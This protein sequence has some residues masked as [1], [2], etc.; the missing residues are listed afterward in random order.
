MTIDTFPDSIAIS[1]WC[2]IHRW[3]NLPY[4]CSYFTMRISCATA[5]LWDASSIYKSGIDFTS[6]WH[7]RWKHMQHKISWLSWCFFHQHDSLRDVFIQKCVHACAVHLQTSRRT[8][9]ASMCF[10]NFRQFLTFVPNFGA[11]QASSSKSKY[12]CLSR[13][14]SLSDRSSILCDWSGFNLWRNDCASNHHF[15][16]IVNHG[17]SCSAFVLCMNFLYMA[18]QFQWPTRV[19]RRRRNKRRRRGWNVIAV[20]KIHRSQPSGTQEVMLS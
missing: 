5:T 11:Q 20:M 18:N 6:F 15:E 19:K 7:A 4:R 13:N 2:G 10:L 9:A 3:F 1:F 14:L 16:Q 17:C 12:S 8:G